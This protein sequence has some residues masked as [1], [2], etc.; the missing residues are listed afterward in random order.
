VVQRA[1]RRAGLNKPG[2]FCFVIWGHD[3]HCA[4]HP[5]WSRWSTSSSRC[6]CRP[7]ATV[8]V[9]PGDSDER[10]VDLVRDGQPLRAGWP[11]A[12]LADS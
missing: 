9:N 4:L 1:D 11:G 12:A 3:F 6:R 8:I 7:D 5:S 2:D 10:R